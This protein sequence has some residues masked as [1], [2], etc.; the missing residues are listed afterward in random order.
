M[1]HDFLMSTISNWAS[2]RTGPKTD[3][4]QFYVFPLRDRGRGDHDFCLSR[5]NSTGNDPISRERGPW[6]GIEPT[7]SW[8]G[9]PPM[10]QPKSLNVVQFY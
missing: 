3:V 1:N 6:V 7:T 4:W 9:V 5:S 10:L 2:S 8:Q